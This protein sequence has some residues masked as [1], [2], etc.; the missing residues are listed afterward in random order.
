MLSDSGNIGEGVMILNLAST[1]FKC[2]AIFLLALL[3]S[4]C[5]TIISGRNYNIPLESNVQ[6][7]SVKI[8]RGSEVVKNS[9]TPGVVMLPAGGPFFRRYSY[10]FEFSKA[11]YETASVERGAGFNPWYVGNVIFGGWIGL[12]LVDPLSGAMWRLDDDPV[13]VNLLKKEVTDSWTPVNDARKRHHQQTE[14]P[15]VKPST[16]ILDRIEQK[17]SVKR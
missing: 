17:P 1:K 12:L 4:G 2:A 15:P 10:K 5:A 3:F 6:G 11:G 9:F 8:Y 7:A 16:S 14:V 13:Q